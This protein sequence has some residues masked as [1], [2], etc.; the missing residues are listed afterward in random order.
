MK[1]FDLELRVKTFG[2]V[3]TWEILLE[4][5]TNHNQ[6]LRDWMQA[7][8]YRYKKLPDYAI[9]DD[10][11]SVFAG[12]QGI[13]GGTVVCEVLINGESQPQKLI[14]KVE[15]TEYAKTDYPIV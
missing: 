2:S 15:E 7:D 10:V 9:S 4:D 1:T 8:D 5:S 6:R 14:S 3:I 13:I 12:C 11:L